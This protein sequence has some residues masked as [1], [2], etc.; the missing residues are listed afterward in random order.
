MLTRDELRFKAL[1][2][3]RYAELIYDGLWM[4][5]LRNALDA[6]NAASAPRM[7]GEVRVRLHHGSCVVTG[8]RSPFAPLRRSACDLRHAATPSSTTRPRASSSCTRCRSRRTR[9]SKRGARRRYGRCDAHCSGAAALHGAPDRGTARVRIVARRRSRAGAVRRGVLARACRGARRR[10]DRRRRAQAAALRDALQA[11]DAE[12]AA[13]TFATYARALGAEDVHGAIDA[14]VRELAGAAGE[15]LHA[16]RS[17]N[18][19]VATTLLL[20]ARDRARL[21]P[22]S[23]ARIASAF[24]A[25]ASEELDGADVLAAAHALAARAARSARVLAR[26]VER[27]VRA[28]RRA[29][30]RASRAAQRDSSPA[31]LRGACAVRAS[32]RS[33]ARGARAGFAAPSRNALDAV[34]D[35]DVALDLA[36]ACVR[37]VVAASRI[38]EEL[39][40]WSTP[41]FG[42]VRLGD[43]A[44]T[45][46]S[47]MPQ[48]RNPDPFELVRAHAAR[49]VADVCRRAGNA[50]RARAVVSSR[51]AGDQ[52]PHD[53]R[54]RGRAGRARCVRPR[55]GG[56]GL[57]ARAHGGAPRRWFYRRDRHRRRADRSRHVAARGARARWSTRLHA[58]SREAR[59]ARDAPLDARASLPARQRAARRRPARCA[60]K[61]RRS[62]VEL[63][64]LAEEL[65]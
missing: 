62:S 21:A 37:A 54:S 32:A 53:R 11:V 9:A 56:G 1:L 31:G 3:Q 42:Y 51:S 10:R 8:V 15:W 5:P 45:G 26:G 20:Y 17:R 61:S 6:F 35:R 2:D 24:V 22:S 23:R 49:L 44:S 34:G 27:A 55:L 39:I 57:R 25:R 33:R 41:A 47:L 48:K 13:G 58:R 63:A 28:R 4:P 40:A 60:S 36:H 14:R 65:E 59:R 18:D 64:N 38:A 50:L 52:E 19:Q 30:S 16:G 46:S 7:T 12:I 29:L 43:A